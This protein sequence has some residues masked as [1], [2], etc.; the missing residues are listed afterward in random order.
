MIDPLWVPT[1]QKITSSN[2]DIF[3][4][5]LNDEFNLNLSNY[6]KLHRWSIQNIDDFWEYVWY[7][8][9]IKHS[10]SFN[11]I[12]DDENKMPGAKWFVGSEL[13]FAENL[14]RIKSDKIALEF[15]GENKIKYTLT[16]NQLHALVS[17]VSYSLKK[18]GLCKGDRVAAIMPNIPETI[19]FMLASVSLGAIWSSCSPDFGVK[20]ILDRF[21]QIEPKILFSTDGYLFKGKVIDITDN[22]SNIKNT[23][24]SI[25]NLIIVPYV[26]ISIP[27][28]FISWDEITNNNSDSIDY[29]QLPFDHPLYIMYSSGTTGKPKSIVHSAG[30]TLIQHFKELKY[31]VNLS[32]NDKIFYYTTCGW[33]MWNWLVS[34]LAFGA[35]L[36]LYDGNPFF[37]EPSHLLKV[38][39]ENQ[40]T[41]FGT[42]AKYIAHVKSLGIHPNKIGNFS[43]LKTILSTGSPLTDDLFD[44][45]YKSWKKNV[46]LSSISGGTDIISC[47]ALGNPCLPVNKGELQCLGL[48]MSVQSYDLNGKSKIDVKGELVC[49]KAFPSMPIYFWNDSSGEKFHS[50]YFD[51]YNNVWAHGDFILINQTGGVK[52]FGR[53]DST[54]NPG[55]VRIGTSEIYETV[56]M[57]DCIEDSL[58]IGQKWNDDE[59]IILFILM[60]KNIT[61]NDSIKQKIIKRIKENCSPRHLPSFILPIKDIPYTINGK[62]VEV[63]VKNIINGIEPNNKESLSNPESLDMFKNIKE[64]N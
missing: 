1:K 27:F 15:Y 58:A 4:R 16:Y 5:K 60:K 49:N 62:K 22:V 34:S 43:K 13:N 38:M 54:L 17:K 47:F 9:K 53:S 2:M 30:G 63:A 32:S 44:F 7:D 6:S 18:M 46:L 10:K 20:G 42:S 28:N 33:M 61:F 39:N 26:N 64:L 11:T 23:I 40:L 3:R 35:T 41:I 24:S 55:G 51:I 19:V 29:E 48:G 8:T 57:I 25:K 21:S 36:V 12:V 14:L 59:R 31:H 56:N 37:P 45:V 52:I 50:A